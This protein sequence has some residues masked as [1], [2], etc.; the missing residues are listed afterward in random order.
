MTASLHRQAPRRR[1]RDTA[2]HTH[3][4]LFPASS[5]LPES[6]TFR[7]VA[8]THREQT[9]SSRTEAARWLKGQGG[10]DLFHVSSVP[11]AFPI[12]TVLLH[13]VQEKLA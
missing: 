9:F 8:R 12:D 7:A 13:T 5:P 1:D 11:L 6:S 2:G 3:L 4:D 10:G